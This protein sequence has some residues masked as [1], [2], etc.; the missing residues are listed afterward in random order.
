[1]DGYIE[2][3]TRKQA[4]I[5]KRL[6]DLEKNIR[7]R[8]N[9]YFKLNRYIADA[10]HIKKRR[11]LQKIKEEKQKQ[12]EDRIKKV[13]KKLLKKKVETIKQQF[14]AKQT[15]FKRIMGN[16]EKQIEILFS[17]CLNGGGGEVGDLFYDDKL[18]S[19]E[20]N[21]I[22]DSV[23]NNNKAIIKNGKILNLKLANSKNYKL[24]TTV[25]QENLVEIIKCET[26]YKKLVKC[27][28][29]KETLNKAVEKFRN[30]LIKFTDRD[31]DEFKIYDEDDKQQLI[32]STHSPRT[33]QQYIKNTFN[34]IEKVKKISS[35][36]INK[37]NDK[38]G[39]NSKSKT[40]F[41]SIQECIDKFKENKIHIV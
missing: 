10:P 33:A 40:A 32:F 22:P 5:K 30:N 25:L 34:K 37:L 17:T 8:M 21:R 19:Y 28:N 26:E 2:K 27:N 35:I 12:K 29:N 36:I 9:K 7:R 15:R 31:N 38:L 18:Y 39:L 24:Y 23:L 1:M 3:N 14:L 11:E 6:N 41:E 13:R 16:I 4:D 20:S